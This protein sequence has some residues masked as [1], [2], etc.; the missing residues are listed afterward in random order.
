MNEIIS[1]TKRQPV[2]VCACARAWDM[3]HFLI[4][5]PSSTELFLLMRGFRSL[6][7]IDFRIGLNTKYAL[8]ILKTNVFLE[9]A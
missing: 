7:S 6:L 2:C 9:F 8:T 3:M 1:F 5:F 4:V